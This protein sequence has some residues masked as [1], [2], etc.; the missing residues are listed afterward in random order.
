MGL[1]PALIAEPRAEAQ[2]GNLRQADRDMLVSHRKA[3]PVNQPRG[4]RFRPSLIPW[5]L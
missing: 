3:I 5:Q 4:L 2:A 1:S